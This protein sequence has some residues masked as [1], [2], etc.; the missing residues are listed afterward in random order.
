MYHIDMAMYE[1]M[2]FTKEQ[3]TKAYEYSQ[4]NKIDIFDALQS[5]QKGENRNPRTSL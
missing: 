3:V 2:G 4:K 5:L 1:Q